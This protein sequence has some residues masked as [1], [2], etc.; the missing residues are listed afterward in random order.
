[1]PGED[2][3]RGLT[4]K[5]IL[6]DRDVKI[7]QLLHLL[8]RDALA[9]ESLFKRGY[10]LGTDVSNQPVEVTFHR[11]YVGAIADLLHDVPEF[12]LLLIV[13]LNEFAHHGSP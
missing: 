8:N 5:C 6:E 10:L 11:L 4:F 12:G 2:L 13:V 1:M 3:A 9:D 7:T